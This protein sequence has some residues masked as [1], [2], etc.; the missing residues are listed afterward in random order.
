MRFL[1]QRADVPSLLAAAEVVVVASS[2]EGQPLVVQETL[3]AGRPLVATRV[4]GIPDLTGEH[5]ALLVPPGD[6][7]GLASAVLAV[8]DDPERAEKLGA[9]ALARAA[10]A[11]GRGHRHRRC[12][13]GLWS[14]RRPARGMAR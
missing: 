5:G 3:R 9:A 4:G 6:A 10:D 11:A 12:P 8:L 7:G 13:G 2:W 14:D 1:G